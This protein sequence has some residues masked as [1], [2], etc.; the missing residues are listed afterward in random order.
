VVA[1][2]TGISAVIAPDGGE[3]SRTDFFQ[4]AYLDMQVR[5]KTRLTPATRWGPLLQWVMVLAA[6]AVILA[7]IR[8]N[9][10]FPR[11]IRRR[12][13]SP[14]ETTRQ[15]TRVGATPGTHQLDE[16]DSGS[17]P[18]KGGDRTPTDDGD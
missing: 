13:R 16:H 15:S 10:W 6:G 4:P 8:H 5:L 17:T 1:G 14:G 12:S 18:D 2:T 11:S 7:G 9:G 3:L